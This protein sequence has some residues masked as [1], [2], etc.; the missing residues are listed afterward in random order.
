[1]NNTYQGHPI[2]PKNLSQLTRFTWTNYVPAAKLGLQCLAD[3]EPSGMIY[4][5]IP[6]WNHLASE[7][8][9][10][11]PTFS[12]VTMPRSDNAATTL[13]V[14]NRDRPASFVMCFCK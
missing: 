4:C 11:F 12:T 3:I 13:C 14:F 6:S 5:C 10:V 7:T 9:F 2:L 8:W 1:M